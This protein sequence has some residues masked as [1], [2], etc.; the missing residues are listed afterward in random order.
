MLTPNTSMNG[1]VVQFKFDMQNH[2]IQRRAS[3]VASM[4]ATSCKNTNASQHS[5]NPS[6][7]DLSVDSHSQKTFMDSL[8][9]LDESNAL[10]KSVTLT[11]GL[12]AKNSFT[13]TAYKSVLASEFLP[14]FHKPNFCADFLRIDFRTNAKNQY[15]LA[16]THWAIHAQSS[17]LERLRVCPDQTEN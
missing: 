9:V 5:R 11:F 3:D 1:L 8:H 15:Q 12:D 13:S 17:I 4:L 6:R 2:A 16:Q 14:C 7:K 10:R